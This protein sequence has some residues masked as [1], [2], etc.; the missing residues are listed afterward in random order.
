MT[1]DAVER[2]YQGGKPTEGYQFAR[3]NKIWRFT[4]AK[5]DVVFD[6]FTWTAVPGLSHTGIEMSA[7]KARNTMSVTAPR[8]F[9]IAQLFLATAPTDIIS[10]TLF[11]FHRGESET[12]VDWIG[13][14]LN[15]QWQGSKAVLSGEPLGLSYGRIGLR[16][17]FQDG[18][19]HVQ[20]QG[21]CKLNKDDWKRE[22]IVTAVDGL[23]LTVDGLDA[24]N[25]A[26]GW[27]EKEDADGNLDLR[28]IRSFDGL[29]LTLTQ[30][31]QDIAPTDEV[32]VYPHCHQNM[33]S[34]D[35]DYH[36]LNNY[37]G[38][39]MFMADKNPFDGTPIF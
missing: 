30:R 9:V 22:C 36:N 10:L 33:Q 26:G 14:V 4:S 27:V 35:D 1:F 29:V 25:Y 20:Y 2:S 7:Q 39:T 11:N 31:F 34:C 18:C 37:G 21:R 15:V 8:D 16:M 3:G 5:A 38:T 12:A 24:L 17:L 6:G 13:R 32:V 19:P 23:Q 28:F